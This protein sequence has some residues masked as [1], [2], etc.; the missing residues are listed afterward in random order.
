MKFDLL[1]ILERI[2][3]INSFIKK[4]KEIEELEKC[5]GGRWYLPRCNNNK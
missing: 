4:I 2:V 1:K 3:N 5:G